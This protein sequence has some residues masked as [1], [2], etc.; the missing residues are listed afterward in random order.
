MPP[1][2]TPILETERLLLR[3]FTRADLDELYDLVY[4][5]PRVK[6]TWSGA[7]GTAE[8]IK[9]RFAAN[10]IDPPGDYGFRAILRKSDGALLGLMGFQT[11][12]PGEGEEIYYLLTPSAPNRCVG[13]DPAV[14]EVE[15]TYALGY[16][17][18]KQGYALEM[19]KAL[20]AWGFAQFGITRIL[21]GVLATNQNSIN[22]MRRLGFHLEPGL[23]ENTVVGVLE[24]GVEASDPR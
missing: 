18:W 14:I 21:Q 1:D 23:A 8:E 15:L 4:A 7:T 24:R 19:G 10:H 12:E 13:F 11:H 20:I 5:D 17:Y 22:L 2:S 3:R 16:A 6:A 9:Q